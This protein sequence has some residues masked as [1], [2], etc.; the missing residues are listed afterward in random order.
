[1]EKWDALAGRG[2]RRR[3]GDGLVFCS[4]SLCELPYCA[5]NGPWRTETESLDLTSLAGIMKQSRA[6]YEFVSPRS[7]Q[8]ISPSYGTCGES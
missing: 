7:E 2:W 6:L 3:C 8:E 1:V 5:H 4:Q